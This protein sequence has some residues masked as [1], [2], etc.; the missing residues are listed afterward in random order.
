MEEDIKKNYSSLEKY[1]FLMCI[2]FELDLPPI[3]HQ[4]NSFED[5]SYIEMLL[6]KYLKEHFSVF[7]EV[8]DMKKETRKNYAM[9]KIETCYKVCEKNLSLYFSS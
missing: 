9:R 5:D 1:Y 8:Y 3:F 2:R 7:K 4:V 6:F